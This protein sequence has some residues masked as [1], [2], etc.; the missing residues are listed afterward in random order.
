V[1]QPEL[2]TPVW[3]IVPKAFSRGELHPVI[4]SPNCNLESCSLWPQL[5]LC[6]VAGTSLADGRNSL[7]APIPSGKMGGR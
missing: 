1:V 6:E 7:L 4:L 3:L 2:G 5:G